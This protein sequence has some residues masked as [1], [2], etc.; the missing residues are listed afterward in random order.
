MPASIHQHLKLA[1]SPEPKWHAP[2]P[3]WHGI[4]C[5]VGRV[6]MWWPVPAQPPTFRKVSLLVLLPDHDPPDTL[7]YIYL[8]TQFL[9]EF[10]GR[11]TVDCSLKG[12]PNA[13]IEN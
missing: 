13:W 11:L 3:T 1:I 5:D 9:V 6:P 10:R 7:P 8:G 4:P 2:L 12:S